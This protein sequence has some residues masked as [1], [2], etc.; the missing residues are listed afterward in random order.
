MRAAYP[1][2]SFSTLSSITRLIL[3]PTISG[4]SVTVLT[5]GTILH[6]ILP[7]DMVQTFLSQ[8]TVCFID[9]PVVVHVSYVRPSGR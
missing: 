9:W 4:R 8:V 7:S 5:I 3:A 2:V 1:S 6:F